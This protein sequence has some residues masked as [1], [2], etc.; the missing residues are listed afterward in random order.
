MCQGL[1][2]YDSNIIEKTWEK[3]VRSGGLF[4]LKFLQL[5]KYLRDS[6]GYQFK[7]KVFVLAL[8]RVDQMKFLNLIYFSF[9]A[10]AIFEK[11]EQNPL[12]MDFLLVMHLAS[13]LNDRAG[14]SL[15][16]VGK[17]VLIIFQNLFGFFFRISQDILVMR[18]LCTPYVCCVVSC[19]FVHI[20]II[21][22]FRL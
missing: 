8:Y 10:R 19:S 2:N 18:F 15:V 22:R 6:D 21:V 9:K 4:T 20:P 3:V 14:G 1:C 12:A 17:I 11:N 13:M 16:L 5:D 7:S